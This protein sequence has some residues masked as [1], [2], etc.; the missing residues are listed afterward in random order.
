MEDRRRG[1]G[2]G[3]A[4]S[5]VWWKLDRMVGLTFWGGR[6]QVGRWRQYHSSFV[7]SGGRREE[8]KSRGTI[9]INKTSP[10][11]TWLLFPSN[12]QIAMEVNLGRSMAESPSPP[13]Y[14]QLFSAA[15]S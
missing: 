9:W 1:R 3:G 13:V 14:G 15:L 5:G 2:R 11:D 6:A 8:R 10:A 4:E 7:K 12:V